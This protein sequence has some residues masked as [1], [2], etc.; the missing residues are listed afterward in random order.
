MPDVVTGS[1][2]PLPFSA[3]DSSILLKS[4][5]DSSS[6]V[7]A[8]LV[9]SAG[10]VSGNVSFESGRGFLRT[11][12]GSAAVT[13]SSLTGFQ[14]L[15]NAGQISF[16]IE[17]SAICTRGSIYG[18]DA[19]AQDFGWTVVWT[20]DGGTT[21]GSLR[22]GTGD[23]S[24]NILSFRN[25]G[26]TNGGFQLH[27]QTKNDY[28]R[29][30]ISWNGANMSLFIDG[31]P[32]VFGTAPTRNSRWANQFT[33]LW[34]MH[35]NGGNG[36]RNRYMRNLIVSTKSAVL[37]THPLIRV[38]FYGH[39]FAANWVKTNNQACYDDTFD[40][41]LNRRFALNG[42]QVA[43]TANGVGGGYVISA[44][45]GASTQLR[46][47][48][49]LNQLASRRATHI[50]V[51]AGTNDVSAAG[52]TR[53][54][55]D[56]DFK[57]MLTSI[58]SGHDRKFVQKIIVATVPSRNGDSSTWTADVQQRILEANDV[59]Q[60]LPA[61]WNS[62]FPARANQLQVVDLFNEW[63]GMNPPRGSMGVMAGLLPGATDNL[64]PVGA[65]T[66]ALARLIFKEIT[67][68]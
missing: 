8:P 53:A 39:S 57:A 30:C 26:E 6:A 24:T 28:V 32:I 49:Y 47:S 54:A 27:S 16:D 11:L 67:P 19:D 58:D 42:Y 46:N 21:F 59:I 25:S 55:F 2:G 62:T 68:P 52:F 63:G 22:T 23:P 18:S 9:G 40:Q 7:T 61:W 44:L 35:F 10:T 43:C 5:L 12:G 38:A 60:A 1:N 3:T 4:T 56:T 64:H 14:A 66:D 15:D 65:G 48:T 36:I 20:P 37:P 13:W 41:I 29:V 34:L 31:V 17:R 51:L 33:A 45:T 50:V